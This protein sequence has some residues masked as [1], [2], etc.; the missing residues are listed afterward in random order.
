M[1]RR[2]FVVSNDVTPGLGLPAAAPGLRAF[3]LAEGLRAHG[4]EVETL[5][6]ATLLEQ[7]WSNPAS[8]PPLQPGTVALGADKLG[9]YLAARQPA[10]VVMTNSNKVRDLQ[11]A[12]GLRYIF[13]FFAPKMLELAYQFGEVHPGDELHELRARK[14]AA[15]ELADAIAV[16]GPKKLGYVLGWVMQT[17]HDPRTFPV[18]V[19]NMAVPGYQHRGSADGALR[20]AIAGYL[21]GW[22]IP[23]PWLAVV[24]EHLA[25][26][27]DTS[28]D[29]LLHAHWGQ[30]GAGLQVPALAELLD[31]PNVRSHAVM[32]YGEFQELLSGVD[33][34]VDLFDHSLER[35][36]AMVTRTVVALACGVPVIH[37]PFTEV[38][39]FIELY[40]A[41]W[42]HAA[43]DVDTLPDLLH[44]ITPEE[45]AAKSANAVRLWVDVF[46]PRRATEPLARLVEA[47]WAEQ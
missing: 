17:G 36:Y 44:S 22:S 11:R 10:T 31:L 39:P 34:A 41:G 30:A 18:E 16:N 7:L 42:L 25:A 5:V 47:V 3:G 8:P 2:V 14:I 28:L 38:S 12:P 27:A 20:Y 19:V 37:P 9:A 26:H 43:E 24:G 23:G 15:L 1:S 6:P 35:E 46:E 33:V 40:D 32:R 13:D 45:A 29:V 21:Q 4:Y